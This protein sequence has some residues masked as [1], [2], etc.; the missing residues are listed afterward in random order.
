[1][2]EEE[3]RKVRLV[4]GA[5]P[6]SPGAPVPIPFTSWQTPGGSAPIEE[7]GPKKGN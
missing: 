4:I 7:E 1:V 2:S 6:R 5:T 3:A